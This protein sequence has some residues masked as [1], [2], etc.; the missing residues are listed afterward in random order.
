MIK[1]TVGRIVIYTPQPIDGLAQNG[2][3][4]LAA[5]VTA[6]W[7][8]TCVNLAVFD[9]N[10][11]PA[12]RTSVLLLQDDAKRPVRL[13]EETG[14]E[15]ETGYF[16]EWMPYQKDLAAKSDLTPR[17]AALEKAVAS[18]NAP[19]TAAELTPA[20]VP[21]ETP[22]PAAASAVTD[23]APAASGSILGDAPKGA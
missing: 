22:A 23:A 20:S 2:N 16:C 14:E 3:E 21:P 10:G 5:I 18:M 19:K 8:D 12:N 7:S 4:P 6:V 13:D 1:P 15:V 11:I 17:I 9:A